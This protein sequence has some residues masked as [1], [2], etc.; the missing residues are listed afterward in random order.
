MLKKT[1]SFILLHLFKM[2]WISILAKLTIHK[3]T[4][5]LD[6]IS[7]PLLTEPKLSKVTSRS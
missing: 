6:S 4:A 5:K 3:I 2:F 7:L 1:T